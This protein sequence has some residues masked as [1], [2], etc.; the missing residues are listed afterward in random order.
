MNPGDEKRSG[1]MV[2][3]I[4]QILIGGSMSLMLL[5]P[6]LFQREGLDLAWHGWIM[7][8]FSFAFLAGTATGGRA[9]G[10]IGCRG[11][12]LTGWYGASAFLSRAFLETRLRHLLPGVGLVATGCLVPFGAL[13]LAF[14]SQP[15]EFAMIGLLF[16]TGHGLFFPSLIQMAAQHTSVDHVVPQVGRLMATMLVGNILGEASAGLMA[17][18]LGVKESLAVAGAF[19][20]IVELSLLRRLSSRLMGENHPAISER[21]S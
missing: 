5:L 20:L 1:M 17:R 3:W 15:G 6:R 18:I 21:R 4:G 14:A 13:A 8:A 16:G 19:A 11:C 10:R 9:I 7:A 12:T 2:V